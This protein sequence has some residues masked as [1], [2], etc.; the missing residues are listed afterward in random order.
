MI[1]SISLLRNIG[2]FDSASGS[3]NIPLARFTL[4][5]AE[6][7]RGKTT[8]AA[9][10]RSLATG[11]PIPISERRR[12][13]AQH[14]PHI[15]LDCSGGPPAAIFQNNTWNRTL[16]NMVVFDDVFVD[17]NVCSGLDVVAEHRQNLHGLI[18]GAQG[19]ILN[20]NLQQLVARIE[21]Q[22]AALRTKEGVIPRSE[23]GTLSIDEFCA[24]PARADI[25]EAI[26][27]AERNLAAANEQDLVHATP[28]FDILNLPQLNLAE[29]ESILQQ[30]LLTL[31]SAAATS[32]PTHLATLGEGAESWVAE[33]M[34]QVL[35]AQTAHQPASCPFCVQSLAGSPIINHYRSYFSDAYAELKNS[36]STIISAID[37]NHGGDLPAAFERAI[38]VAVERKQFWSRFC[39]TP[40]VVL[41][42]AAITRDWRM[43]RDAVRS[44][45]N[46]KNATPLEPVSLSTD[47]QAAI[48]TYEAHRQSIT[49]LNNQLQEANTAIAVTKEQAISGNPAALVSDV[50]RLRAVKARHTPELSP[51]CN[52]YLA[53]KASKATTE[54]QRDRGC[55][56]L[57]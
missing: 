22:N 20:Q 30:D 11:D 43:A 39:D 53:E 3:S 57:S 12:L 25:D 33:G 26:Q 1:I 55:V 41:D 27:A 19:V 4:V 7:G 9:V 29:I 48:A 42:T 40:Q 54:Q 38:R 10:L 2:Q 14:P 15:V 8:L 23:Q 50:N 32:V 37:L 51:L 44:A 34:A 46:T 47:A 16:S 35:R 24:L 5:Y 18:L 45:L 6:N 28:T 31:D 36:I 52:D 56:R 49:I 13:A 21:A 17:Q